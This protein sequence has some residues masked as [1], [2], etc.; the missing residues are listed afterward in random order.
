MNKLIGLNNIGNTCYLNSALQLLINCTV[1]TKIIL[2][3]NF[4][5]AKLNYIKNFFINYFNSEIPICPNKLKIIVGQKSNKF[6]SFA[7]QD[8]HEFLIY[9]LEILEEEFKNHFTNEE[10]CKI[11]LKELISSL[12]DIGITSIIYSE[13][14]NEQSKTHINER[15]LSLPIKKGDN[16]TLNDCIND[17]LKVEKLD[18]DS[19]WF[20]QKNN[21]NV[22]AYKRL[23]LKRLPKYLIIHLKRFSYF[24]SSNKNNKVVKCDEK[25]I[26]EDRNYDLRG[27]VYHSGTANGGHYISVIK[28]NGE[29]YLC[30]DGTITKLDNIE[31]YLNYGYI[32]LY[33]KQK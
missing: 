32:Y 31:N 11:K 13:E 19:K 22:V 12:F 3:T 8:S 20:S 21:K 23:I 1:L 6:M 25:I 29:W 5:N 18:G 33:V 10:I 27:I 2:T 28:L 14:T 4:N 17:F 9:L 26:I 30:N 24:S 7:Q 16:I 15:I